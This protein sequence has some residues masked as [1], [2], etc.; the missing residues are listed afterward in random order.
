[1]RE[2]KVLIFFWS[3]ANDD[4][5][6]HC[7]Y[8]IPD[9]S[10][11]E[12]LCHGLLLRLPEYGSEVGGVVMI[13]EEKKANSLLCCGPLA[14]TKCQGSQCMAWRWRIDKLLVEDDDP[15]ALPREYYTTQLSTTHGYCGLAGKP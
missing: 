13:I 6:A 2:T 14:M 9:P 15:E 7:V 11:H 3:R 4:Q 8:K 1:M 12:D 10:G 5:P